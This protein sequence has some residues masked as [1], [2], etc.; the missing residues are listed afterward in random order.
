METLSRKKDK[1]QN[2]I[3]HYQFGLQM[4]LRTY[5]RIERSLFFYGDLEQ[6]MK[7]TGYNYHLYSHV[8]EMVLKLKRRERIVTQRID[9]LHQLISKAEY[10]VENITTELNI[11]TF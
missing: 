2:E 3:R 1:L 4:E 6:R 8:K 10:Q 5:D 9:T 11:E 7:N